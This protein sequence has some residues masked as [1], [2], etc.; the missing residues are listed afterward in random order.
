MRCCKYFFFQ[1]AIVF[2]TPP[3]W[4]QQN[5]DPV[6]VN[7]FLRCPSKN[8]NS[9]YKQFKYFPEDPGEMLCLCRLAD[10][11]QQSSAPDACELESV[12]FEF[13]NLSPSSVYVSFSR[14]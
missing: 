14:D 11:L 2:K 10:C 9:E 6:E 1:F 3:Y 7:M 4:N 12:I 5:V 13:E 8:Q